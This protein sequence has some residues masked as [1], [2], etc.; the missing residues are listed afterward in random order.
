MLEDNSIGRVE[1][2]RDIDD[3]GALFQLPEGIEDTIGN[4][5]DVGLVL[6]FLGLVLAFLLAGLVH[7]SQHL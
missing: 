4:D 2:L 3:Y 5:H 6:V 7:V 1:V